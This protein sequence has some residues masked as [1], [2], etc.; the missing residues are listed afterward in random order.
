MTAFPATQRI[1]RFVA[2]TTFDSLP[3]AAVDTTRIAF[4][5][6]LGVALAGSSDS[7]ASLVAR[8]VREEA[9]AERATVIGHDFRSSA[10]Q[11]AFANG[12]AGHALDYD[13]SFNS[14]GQPT[15]PLIPAVL[16]VEL[17][18]W[19]PGTGPAGVRH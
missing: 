18:A 11:A 6:L 14:G 8:L 5:D 19:Q 12:V 15:S 7:A 17:Q 4:L 13:H 10:Q 9:A 3:A 16:A 1:A 2:E